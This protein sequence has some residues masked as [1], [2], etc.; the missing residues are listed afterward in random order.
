MRMQTVDFFLRM[1]LGHFSWNVSSSCLQ[2]ALWANQATCA[3]S[4]T[5]RLLA[6]E[7]NQSTTKRISAEWIIYKHKL[8]QCGCDATYI[9]EWLV[10]RSITSLLISDEEKRKTKSLWANATELVRPLFNPCVLE[11]VRYV[12]LM[13]VCQG[14]IL[15]ALNHNDLIT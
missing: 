11:T 4:F 6:Q 12:R 5:S 2:I 15:P 14:I 7:F 3:N 8:V 10:K 1:G 9:L 13:T